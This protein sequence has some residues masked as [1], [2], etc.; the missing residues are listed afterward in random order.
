MTELRHWILHVDVNSMYASCERVLDPSL[1]GVPVVVLSNNDGCVI[2]AS[3]EAKALGV[4]MGDPWFKILEWASSRGV[5][6]RSSNYELVGLLSGRVMQLLE[7][8]AADVEIYSVDEA[9]LRVRSDRPHQLGRQIKEEIARLIGLPVCVGVARTKVLAKLA[10]KTAKKIPGFGGV[11][12]W[13][14]IPEEARA[15]LTGRLP[16]DQVWGIASGLSRRLAGEGI[17]SVADLMGAD[18]VRMRQRHSVVLMRLVLELQGQPAVPREDMRE[19]QDQLIFSRAF[20]QPVTSREEMRQ[21]LALYVQRAAERLTARGLRAG[22]LAAFCS[23]GHFAAGV[24][25]SPHVE[26]S[27]GSATDDPVQLLRAAARLLDAADFGVVRYAR[28]GLI[29][30]DLRSGPVQGLLE[31]FQPSAAGQ[32]LGALLER[33]NSRAGR[34]AIGLGVAGLADAPRWNMRRDMLSPRALTHWD[35]LPAVKVG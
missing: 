33:I 27:L 26:V 29:L 3:A 8:F 14:R 15:E 24:R 7:R 17:V 16:V 13:D 11:C 5:V 9:F 25:S 1:E 20:S 32:G 10:N 31:P 12:V 28:A 4:G 34:G 2:A 19:H 22:H 21:V 18:P 35:E 6:A 30:T 23:T